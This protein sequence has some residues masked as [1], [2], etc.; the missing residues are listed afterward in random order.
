MSSRSGLLFS[1]SFC[2]LPHAL[3][4]TIV[5]HKY[6][7]V[8]GCVCVCACCRGL[9]CVPCVVCGAC[10]AAALSSCGVPSVCVCR[11]SRLPCCSPFPS[12]CRSAPHH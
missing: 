5:Q 7:R 11:T 9:E 1:R 6:C 2:V 8:Q 10:V 4:T 3:A 12:L